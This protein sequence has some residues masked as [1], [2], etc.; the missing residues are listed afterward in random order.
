MK[1]VGN[2]LKV[3]GNYKKKCGN[4]ILQNMEMIGNK[5]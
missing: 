4:G 5:L 2:L 1:I 3:D